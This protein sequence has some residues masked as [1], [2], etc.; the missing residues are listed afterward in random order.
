MAFRNTSRSARCA[1]ISV[2]RI[3][4]VAEAAVGQPVQREHV[5]EGLSLAAVQIRRVIVD[6]EQGRRVEAIHPER[7]AAVGVVAEL[8]GIGDVERPHILEIVEG[9]GRCR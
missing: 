6:A 7:R 3:V 5:G 4:L 9:E 1:A 2:E 8:Q